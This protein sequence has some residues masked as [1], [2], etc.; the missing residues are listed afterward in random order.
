MAKLIRSGSS[1]SSALLTRILERSELVAAVPKLSAPVLGQLIEHVGLEDAGELVAVASTR[2][3]ERVWD[4]DLWTRQDGDVQER[5]DPERF[6]TWLEVMLEA[7]EAATAQRLRELPFDMLTLAVHRMVR[8][9]D[10]VTWSRRGELGLEED[11]DDGGGGLFAPWNELVLV[12]RDADAW[13]AVLAALLALDQEDHALLRRVLE[14]CCD[15]VVEGDPLD[16]E[17]VGERADDAVLERD[18]A[19]ERDRRQAGSGFVSASDARGFL[20]QARE[21]GE[22]GQGMARD[23]VTTAYFRELVDEGGHGQGQGQGQG[24]GHDEHENEHESEHGGK[25]AR[26][27][28]GQGELGALLGVLAEAGVLAGPEPSPVAALAA[29]TVASTSSARAAADE[30]GTLLQAGLRELEREEP[31]LWSTRMEEL[32]YLANVVLA[33]CRDGGREFSPRAALEAASA[34]CSVGLE[35]QLP[36]KAPVQLPAALDALRAVSA[37]R[38]FRAGFALLHHQLVREAWRVLQLRVGRHGD[39]ELRERLRAAA[40]AEA[41][42]ALAGELDGDLLRVRQDRLE[43]LCGLT[44]AIPTLAGSLATAGTR[45]VTTRVQLQ[46]AQHLLRSLRPPRASAV[47]R[48]GS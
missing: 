8:V 45:F 35:L 36:P 48:T 10:R 7:G 3:L 41:L 9:L 25:L 22:R 28:S 27:E 31:L 43:A 33:G 30:A 13:D 6:G 11:D 5:F 38:L 2:Q 18:V 44:E 37:D 32:G 12:S 26:W 34:V 46:D 17:D 39:A 40:A 29:G 14:R 24:Q 21:R 47:R 4:R 16:G 42:G 19:A 23:A 20:S 1:S 15:L